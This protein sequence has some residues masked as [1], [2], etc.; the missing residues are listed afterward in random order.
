[1]TTYLTK[2]GLL[3]VREDAAF[4]TSNSGEFRSLATDEDDGDFL[5]DA[6]EEIII[7]ADPVRRE[8]G[9][10]QLHTKLATMKIPYCLPKP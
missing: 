10:M 5:Q 6:L 3:V 1:M 2:T 8:S 9:R 4:F 7:N